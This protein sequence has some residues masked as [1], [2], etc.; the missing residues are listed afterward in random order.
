MAFNLV[1]YAQNDPQWKSDILGFSTSGETLERVGCALSSVAMLLSGYGFTE[2]PKSLNQKLKNIQGF[3]NSSIRWQA[4]SQLYPQVKIASG[5]SPLQRYEN[6]DAPLGMI[7]AALD[8]GHPVVVRVDATSR[9]DFQWHFVL[10]YARNG[11]D[12]YLMLDPWPYKPGT[13]T[14]DSLMKRYSQGQ[15]LRR[16]IQQVVLYD[17]AG[18]GGPL[19]V[20]TSGDTTIPIPSPSQPVPAPT[21]GSGVY[22]RVMD[23]VTS[24]LNIRSS[25]NTSSIDNILISVMP[26]TQLLLLDAADTGKIGRTAQWVRVREPGG[27]EGFAAAWYLEKI[28]GATPS[29]TPQPAPTPSNETTPSPASGPTPPTPAQSDKLTVVVSDAVGTAGLRL[30]KTP[31]LG[32]AVLMVL[33]AGTL[34]TVVEPVG[35][36]KAKI[37]QANRWIQVREPGGG[38]G[39][40]GAAY[41]KLA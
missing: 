5:V 8:A 32:G 19:N 13:N 29:P 38:R 23:S 16:A 25:T 4:V 15:P 27:K 35:K 33:K 26:G 22:A 18:A 37:G 12:D 24:G 39:F 2:T 40:V 6:V 10:V 20:P 7:N 30:R 1:Y 9:P 3:S 41:V 17:V 34:L 31:S 21:P 14:Q 36:A 11:D 28:P